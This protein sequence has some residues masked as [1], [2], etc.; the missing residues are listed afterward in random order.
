MFKTELLHLRSK[1]VRDLISTVDIQHRTSDRATW[2]TVACI[3]VL[4]LATTVQAVHLCG[5]EI[6]TVRATSQV[7]TTSFSGGACLICLMAQAPVAAA[8]V[9]VFSPTSR[10][11]QAE[12][13]PEVRT[14]QLLE[15]F[16]LYVR[17]PPAC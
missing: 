17:P 14:G 12:P 15:F 10:P 7:S 9:V 4:L 5:Q 11:S 8:P 3:F 1:R 2:L 6:P 16:Q 13:L